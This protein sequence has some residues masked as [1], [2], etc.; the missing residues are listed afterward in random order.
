MDFKLLLDKAIVPSSIVRK[1]FINLNIEVN[2]HTYIHLS[3]FKTNLNLNVAFP[4][5]R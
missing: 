5:K 3:E 2:I 4:K 1:V